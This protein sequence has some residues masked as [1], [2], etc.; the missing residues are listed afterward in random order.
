[1]YYSVLDVIQ[2]H[3]VQYLNGDEYVAKPDSGLEQFDSRFC[4]GQIK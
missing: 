1:M 3:V 4:S 2:S